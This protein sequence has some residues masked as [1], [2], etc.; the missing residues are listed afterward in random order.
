[1]GIR[2]WPKAA[3]EILGSSNC[4]PIKPSRPPARF[5]AIRLPLA[6]LGKITCASPVITGVEQASE[7]R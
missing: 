7:D 3:P 1:M 4:W 6:W 2:R 5:E